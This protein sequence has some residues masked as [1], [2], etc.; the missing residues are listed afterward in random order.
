MIFDDNLKRAVSDVARRH[1]LSLVA[2]FGS[3]VAGTAGQESDVD[4]AVKFRNGDAGLRR[5]LEVQRDLSELFGDRKV[6][7][8]VINRA[9]PLFM[10]KIAERC[11][12][13]Y[14]ETGEG[15]AFLLLA[16]KRYHDHGK[17]LKMERDF[18][19]DYVNRIAP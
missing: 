18:A 8:S 7:L 12:F 4:I 16:F 14:E 15:N 6:D 10:K 11:L 19:I 5:I 13:L 17:Y 1:G 3:I 2:A 9:D